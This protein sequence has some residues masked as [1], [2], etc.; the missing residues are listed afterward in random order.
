M[1]VPGTRSC[2]SGAGS[3]PRPSSSPGR[4]CAIKAL[5]ILSD[6]A[7]WGTSIRTKAARS[8]A[9]SSTAKLSPIRDAGAQDSTPRPARQPR[10]PARCPRHPLGQA[11]TNHKRNSI[12]SDQVWRV[13]P[14]MRSTDRRPHR[15]TVQCIGDRRH[16]LACSRRDQLRL[17]RQRRD[18]LPQRVHERC[19]ARGAAPPGPRRH[20][21]CRRPHHVAVVLAVQ[22]HRLG[23][24]HQPPARRRHHADST[25]SRAACRRA[26]GCA[27][28]SSAAARFSINVQP[29]ATFCVS[30]AGKSRPARRTGGDRPMRLQFAHPPAPG[31][32]NTAPASRPAPRQRRQ[33][34]CQLLRQ[35][36]VVLV[37]ERD[38]VAAI[39]TCGAQQSQEAFARPTRPSL[40]TTTDTAPGRAWP[41]THAP[42]LGVPS[43]EPSSRQYSRQSRASAPQAGELLGRNR[44]PL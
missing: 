10:L 1:F 26:R 17:L 37:G 29:V 33:A 43:A 38:D 18:V 5:T 3:R 8:R 28:I 39:G 7:G 25:T 41:G 30:A 24:E 42:G 35:P 32:R 9:G 21:R 36:H 13:R 20:R 14:R 34:A 23:V 11:S 22:H 16:L 4:A 44:S 31:A 19:R 6:F 12:V 40:G 27:A 2:P 15:A